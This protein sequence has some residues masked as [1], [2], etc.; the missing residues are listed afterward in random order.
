[1]VETTRLIVKTMR[2][3]LS[4]DSGQAYEVLSIYV[5]LVAIDNFNNS[6]AGE[7]LPVAQEIF[8]SVC[9]ARMPALVREIDEA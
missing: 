2:D 1:M 6:P 7:A 5:V 9:L 8:L 4:A 3:N